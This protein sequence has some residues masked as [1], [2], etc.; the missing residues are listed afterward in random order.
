MLKEQNSPGES[1]GMQAVQSPIVRGIDFP[2][3]WLLSGGLD[4]WAT[5]IPWT[6]VGVKGQFH[7]FC[8]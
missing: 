6:R 4:Q 5:G 2:G 8:V 3:P 7:F 1:M